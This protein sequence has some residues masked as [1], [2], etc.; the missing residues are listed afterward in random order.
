MPRLKEKYFKEVV[1]KLMEEFSYKSIMQV[2]RLEKIVLN[3][4]LGE[5]INNIK[6]LDA[7]VEELS[8]IAGQKAVITKAKKSIAGFKLRKGM[9]IGC[10]V[11]LRGDRM[12]DFLDKLISIA[13]PRIRDF[14]GL[15]T[16]SFDGRGNYS[17]G[18]KEQYIFPEIDYDKVEMVHGFDITIC[19]TAETDEEGKALLKYLGM[20]FRGN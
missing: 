16:R 19:T 17:M 4:G 18:V 14:R 8:L 7:A 6:L 1:P 9:P 13:I 15:T 2:P 3:C 20:P 5:A 11:T 10:K 12:Y